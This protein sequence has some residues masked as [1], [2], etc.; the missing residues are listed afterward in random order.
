MTHAQ[1]IIDEVVKE[2]KENEENTLYNA[3][4]I[5]LV[6]GIIIVVVTLIVARPPPEYFTELYF[7]NHTLLPKYV[8]ANESYNFSAAIHN[9]EKGNYVYSIRVKADLYSQNQSSSTAFDQRV[10]VTVNKG[11]TA[12]LPVKFVIH[13]PFYRMK[14]TTE[15]E[16]KGQEIHFWSY[17]KDMVMEYE[18]TVA[19]VSCLKTINL[20]PANYFT[21]YAKGTFNPNMKVRVNGKQIYNTTVANTEFSNY[22]VGYPIGTGTM[23]IIYGNDYYNATG[24]Q[25]RNLYIDHIQ[26]GEQMIYPKQGIVDLGQDTKAFDCQGLKN[27]TQGILW[28]AALRLRFK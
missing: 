21:I 10:N 17:N 24:K 19:S 6:I 15:L 1:K 3:I 28:N 8:S 4:I 26:I 25:D 20:T 2:E 11:T 27:A 22:T 14:V 13:E 5:S 12:I 9:L 18:D 16:N 23:D 7:N